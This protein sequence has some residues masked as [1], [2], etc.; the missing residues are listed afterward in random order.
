MAEQNQVLQSK[1]D[2]L[3]ARLEL[4][5]VVTA[6][7][8]MELVQ[9]KEEIARLRA[10]GLGLAKGIASN[11]IRTPAAN[12]RVETVAYLAEVTTEIETARERSRPE[13][14]ELF[15]EADRFMTQSNRELES[16]RYEQATLLAA[17]ALEL[18]SRQ[19]FNDEGEAKI[20]PETYND[21]IAPLDLK[22]AKMSNIRKA[23]GKRGKL[24]TTVEPGTSVT[25]IGHK[26][27]WIKVS[28]Q[29]GRG[30]WIYYSLLSIP[31]KLQ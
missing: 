27:Y 13:D 30:G 21:F 20:V 16:D 26:G 8:Q 6:R 25:A 29:D 19:R 23:P 10:A 31:Q 15:A 22:V 7:L 1:V 18:I 4:Q 24:V 5:N 14:Q 3:Q 28:L 12:T 17:Q 2:N 9:K 11:T